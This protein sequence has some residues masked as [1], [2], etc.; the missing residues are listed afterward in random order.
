[1]KRYANEAGSIAVRRLLGSDVVAI[2]RLSE[3]EV[4]SAI[5][6]RAREGAF[7]QRERDRALAALAIDIEVMHVVE[8]TP[9]VTRKARGLLLR[10]SLRAGDA[11]QLASCVFLQQE[12]GEPVTFA[13]FDER[14][15][16]AARV[17]GL[18]PAPAV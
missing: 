10:H 14:L 16:A 17:E 13:V 9:E 6:R 8:L 12:L 7:S 11:T 18:S 2:S 15:R 3:V 1:M 4:A 5:V